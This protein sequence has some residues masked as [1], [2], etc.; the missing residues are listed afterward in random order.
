MTLEPIAYTEFTDGVMRPVYE[1]ARGQFVFDDDGN[2]ID[3]ARWV[4]CGKSTGATASLHEPGW[5]SKALIPSDV[6]LFS[7]LVIASMLG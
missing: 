6:M 7:C 2:R 5:K 3:G 4:P 1:D